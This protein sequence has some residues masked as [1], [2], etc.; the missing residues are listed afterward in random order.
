M[1]YFKAVEYPEFAFR[2]S[3]VS[4]SAADKDLLRELGA[5]DTVVVAVEHTMLET[6]LLKNRKPSYWL[7]HRTW[8]EIPYSPF[9]IPHSKYAPTLFNHTAST[10][11]DNFS[12]SFADLNGPC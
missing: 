5:G 9:R 4:Y 3:G 12:K 11:A 7:K 6:K 1:I 10:T 8:D 2:V